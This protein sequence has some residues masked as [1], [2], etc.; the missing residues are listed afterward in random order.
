MLDELRV[1]PPME[2]PLDASVWQRILDR[3]TEG[4]GRP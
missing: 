3:F 4:A 1:V 2:V